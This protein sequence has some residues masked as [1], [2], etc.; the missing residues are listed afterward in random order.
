MKKEPKGAHILVSCARVA[1]EM[2]MTRVE[3]EELETGD[4]ME[5]ES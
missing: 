4:N 1:L 2:G 3:P 5:V